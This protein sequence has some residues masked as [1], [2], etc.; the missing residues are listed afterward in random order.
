LLDCDRYYVTF[1]SPRLRAESLTKH[2]YF[3]AHCS[4]RQPFLLLVNAWQ[5]L[6][7]LLRERPDVILSTGADVA[8]ATC[9]IGKLLGAKLIYV[10]SGGNVHTP[11]LSGRIVY[12]FADLFLIQWEPLRKRY[13]KAVVGGPLL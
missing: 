8:V 11:S 13:P 9:L 3:V 7:I 10:E 5:S 12:P 1:Y 2:I 6:R 4:R